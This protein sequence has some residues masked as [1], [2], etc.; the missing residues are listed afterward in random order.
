MD[1][2]DLVFAGI[3]QQA[4]L[5]R[6]GEISSREL[7][8]ACLDRIEAL[9]PRL[10]AWRI[11]LAE[12]AL[13]EADQADGRRG[14]GDAR[15][16]LGVPVAIKD[17]VD[18]A[19][20]TTAWGSSAHGA[21]VARDAVVVRRLREAGAIV[22]GKTN[23][24]E[25]TIFPFTE[26]T[27]FGVTRNPWDPSRTTGGSSGGT[28]AAVASGMVGAGLGSDGG[29]SIRIPSAWCGL[30]GIKPTRGRVSLT[31]HDDAWQGL[32]VNGPIARRVADAALFLDACAER[33]PERPFSDAVRPPERKLKIA[34]SLKKLP[35]AAPL[36]RL[37]RE[38]RAATERTAELLSS[39]G[40]EV[41]ERDPDYG[42]ISFPH[43]LARYLRG[44]KEDADAMPHPERLE[45]RTLGMRRM[46]G[47]WS[48]GVVARMRRGE[49][50][51]RDRAWRSLDGAD[52]LMTPTVALPPPPIGKWDGK[53]AFST[54]N[55]VAGY[56]P[57]NAF[58]NLTGQ[59]AVSVPA[60]LSKAGL[61][62]AVQLVAPLDDEHTL[63]SLAA[64]LEAER[65]WA[66]GR[67]PVS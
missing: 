17:D 28:A 27:T 32:S 30:F 50:A 12:K 31:P 5:I 9:D 37:D 13:A 66:D 38:W 62:L 33:R 20:T 64:Q 48:P 47:M 34:W 57:Y 21:E 55:G 11:V 25:L 22:L 65:P 40:H 10:N 29:G 61:P 24:P 44:I 51:L 16:L 15:P 35:G 6:D 7:V 63:I 42:L 4:E 67:P 59:P 1:P 58:F 54:L 43:F 2:A 14:A 45:K 23:V 18:V 41:V 52:V 39:L 19:G 49:A 60:G 3:A 46:G 53:S 56:V 26:T 8:E 36:P